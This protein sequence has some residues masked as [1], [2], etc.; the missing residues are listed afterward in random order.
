MVPLF[1]T[2][3]LLVQGSFCSDYE[4]DSS[5]Y[6]VVPGR[7]KTNCTCGWANKDTERIFGGEETK[8]N[9]FPY[10]AGLINPETKFLFCGGTII[11]PFHVLTAAHCTFRYTDVG[12]LPAVVVGEH[13]RTD[14]ADKSAEENIYMVEKI[15]E[16][17]D[18]NRLSQQYDIALLVLEREI[19]FTREIGPACLPTGPVDVVGKKLKVLGWGQTD[20]DSDYSEVLM[21]VNLDAVPVKTCSEKTG[22]PLPI[23]EDRN[24]CTYT[25]GKDTCKGDSGGPLLYVDP[26]SNR[27]TLV[28]VIS[29]GDTCGNGKPGVNT[30]VTYYIDWIQHHIAASLK[31]VKTCSK[32]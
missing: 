15:I 27:Y 26:E 25:Q 11:S 16:H 18:H 1:L 13:S 22:V 31:G 6:G 9:E 24:I 20:I 3:L 32:V 4:E 21:K 14:V 5:E 29:Y 7:K 8:V 10:M 2:L 17:R 23:K 28:G 19:K 12:R 30:K